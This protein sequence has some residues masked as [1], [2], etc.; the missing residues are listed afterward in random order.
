MASNLTMNFSGLSTPLSA[1][2]FHLGD[3]LFTVP[4]TATPGQSYTVDLNGITASSAGNSVNV[5]AG[6]DSTVTITSLYLVGDVFP[7]TTDSVGG[8]GDGQINTLDLLS[9]LRAVTKLPGA[10][11]LTCSDRFDAMDVYPVDV[12]GTRGGDGVL[13]TLDI[14]ALLRRVTNVDMSRPTRTSP[15]P[16]PSLVSEQTRV[17]ETGR[18]EGL[19]TLAMEGQR[20][21][22]YLRANVDLSLSGLSFALGSGKSRMRFTPASAHAPTLIDSALAGKL[23][24]AWLGGLEARAGDRMLLGYVET[25]G[26]LGF[27][28]TSA[29]A[30]GT[31]RPVRIDTVQLLVR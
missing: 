24:L 13:N 20:T 22:I 8:F 16:C 26:S 9:L 23:A 27:F 11:P 17:P 3:V 14:L 6:A 30:K 21:A 31:G 25:V 29:N 18:P 2:E 10:V 12:G 4:S 5:T 19:L 1:N 15:P 28:G 7:S